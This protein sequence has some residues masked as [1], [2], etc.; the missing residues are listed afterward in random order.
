[1]DWEYLGPATPRY[2]FIDT[3]THAVLERYYRLRWPWAGVDWVKP[4]PASRLDVA[5]VESGDADRKPGQ[6][7]RCDHLE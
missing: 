5:D 3:N 6:V 1:V 7:E 2:E 4:H